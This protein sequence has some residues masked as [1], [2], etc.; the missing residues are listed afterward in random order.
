LQLTSQQ[1][2]AIKNLPP[3]K[4]QAL[5]DLVGELNNAKQRE[6]AANDFMGF[7][8]NV[9][10]GFI[11]G[12]H[13]QIMADAFDRIVSGELKRLIICM[14]PRH[15]KSEFAS[16]HLPAYYLGHHPDR[17]I[18][19]ASHTGELAVGFGRKARDLIN[20]DRYREIFPNTSLKADTKAAGRWNTTQGGN[21]FAVGVGGAVTGKGGD[22]VII[23][24]AHSEQDGQSGDA[25][26]FD[27]AYEW[28]T[29]GPRQRLQPG[30][31]IVIV[32]TRWHVRDLTGR[33]LSASLQQDGMDEWELIEFPAIFDSGQ[34]N[35]RPLW[36]EFWPLEQ[37]ISLRNELPN[38]KWQAQYQ[39]QPTSEEGALI[40]REWW[41]IW[42]RSRPPECD[43][44]IQSWDT[45]FTKDERNDLSAC[46]LW[47]VFEQPD[48]EGLPQ[49]NII[50][51]HAMQARLE[52][53]ELKAKALQMYQQEKPDICIIE[54]KASG[55]PLIYEMRA[56][57]V[58]V[59]QFTPSRGNDKTVRVNA[60]TDLFASGIVWRPN[61][62]WAEEVSDQCAAFPDGDHDD[63]VD[64]T[65]QAL[66][67][68]RQ[69]G[70]L[71]LPDDEDEEDLPPRE[72][73]NYY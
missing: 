65:T 29:S 24:D 53:P 25:K 73:A 26:V 50:L 3:E 7:V 49:T 70:F 68:F 62:R 1:K 19:Q 35:E 21:Y 16:I 12:R 2:A 38:N 18:I 59:Q 58:P 15:S 44:I 55:L 56:K 31:A 33:I 42:E 32:M 61:T 57:G 10:D 48:L 36:P 11:G 71:R 27:R 63:L 45:A 34:E 8:N 41:K 28:Y 20:S 9:W 66:L 5:M 17:K 30:G 64:S 23:D 54:A 13:H 4:Q 43:F 6:A 47:G 51:L 69:G 22:L 72:K 46:T 52:F 39:Q 67:R 37:L 14:P 40:K 60:V